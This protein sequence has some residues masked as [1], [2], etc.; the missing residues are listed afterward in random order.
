[1]GGVCKAERRQGS[2]ESVFVKRYAVNSPLSASQRLKS[3][4]GIVKASVINRDPIGIRPVD[5]GAR[6]TADNAQSN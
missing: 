2:G 6:R 4:V 1:M 3:A 5:P